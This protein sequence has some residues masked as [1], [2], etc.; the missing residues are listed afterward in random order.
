MNGM[1]NH[2]HVSIVIP[3]YNGEN[4]IKGCLDSIKAQDFLGYEIIVVDDA[5]TDDSLKILEAYPEVQ[6]LVN[7]ENL[8]FA[9][10]VNRGIRA[11]VGTYVL[12]LNNDV[13]LTP[14]FLKNIIRTAEPADVFGV[15]SRMIR[16]NE[17]D[18]ID[19]AGDQYNIF[20]WGYKRGDGAPLFSFAGRE[21]VFSVCAG[22]GLYKRKVFGEIG[23]FDERFFAY[24]EDMDISYRARIY[25]YRNMY[26][27][28]AMCYHVGS[29]TTAGGER[30]SPF[31]VKLSARNNVY[32]IYKNMPLP[33]ILLNSP[34]LAAGFA[35]KSAYFIQKGYG[36]AYLSGLHEGFKTMRGLNRI[37]YKR[38]HLKNY[39][40][41]EKKLA[42][43]A[44]RYGVVKLLDMVTPG[45]G[46][47]KTTQKV[48]PG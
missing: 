8:G 42:E 26:E 39:M 36:K 1:K 2:V 17:R 23:L 38:K 27:P 47:T 22:A 48:V 29:A 15:S 7:E 4:Y 25:G 14:S 35:I 45:A 5:S 32:L 9:A 24:M 28:S 3:N 44:V 20:G 19:D 46:F 31:K 43:N 37:P 33:Q 13:E 12:L 21:E 41:I 11:S 30:Y 18:K 16:F 34:F 10:S 6:V 40:N